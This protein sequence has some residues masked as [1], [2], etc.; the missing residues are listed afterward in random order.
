MSGKQLQAAS[1]W[2]WSF[3]CFCSTSSTT[4][5]ILFI[6]SV[7]LFAIFGVLKIIDSPTGRG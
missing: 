3:C 1:P 6:V 4:A 5:A 7:G 2:T